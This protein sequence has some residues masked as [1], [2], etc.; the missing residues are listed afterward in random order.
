M[1]WVL[2][3]ATLL[4]VT[5]GYWKREALKRLTVIA[6]SVVVVTIILAAFIRALVVRIDWVQTPSP[7]RVGLLIVLLIVTAGVVGAMIWLIGNADT[8][9]TKKFN[10]PA[11]VT[12]EPPYPEPI[13]KIEPFWRRLFRRGE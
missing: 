8:L 7:G 2:F 13:Q 6:G 3:V 4:V 5:V 1:E 12:D 9:R 11:N 10:T